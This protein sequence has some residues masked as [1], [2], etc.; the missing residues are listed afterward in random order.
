MEARSQWEC[1]QLTNSRA[2]RSVTSH[3]WC[4]ES[5]T[6][7]AREEEHQNTMINIIGT[8]RGHVPGEAPPRGGA[9]RGGTRRGRSTTMASHE[10]RG[11][12][13]GRTGRGGESKGELTQRSFVLEL[14]QR[15]A[16]G[17]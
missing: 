8:T 16:G 7:K 5:N 11:R 17:V 3:Y 2:A 13:R 10:G 1:S 4:K 14:C 6:Q 9:G 15:G 12:G